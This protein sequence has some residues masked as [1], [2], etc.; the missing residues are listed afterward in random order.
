MALRAKERRR[1]NR[2]KIIIFLLAISSA[3]VNISLVMDGKRK[4]IHLYNQ[5]RKT[6]KEGTVNYYSLATC[7]KKDGK[8]MKEVIQY[9]GRLSDTEATNYRVLLKSLNGDLATS[10]LIDIR[11]ILFKEEK[12]YFDSLVIN[13]LW[14]QLDINE[15]FN[16]GIKGNQALST[17]QVARILTIN[18]LLDPTSKIGTI[19]WL[20][21]TL[22]PSIL[23]FDKK[24]YTKNKI[25]N[26]L[27]KIH[28]SKAYLEKLFWNFSKSNSSSEFEV[29]Y[30]DG[31][32]SWFEGTKC[33]LAQNALEKTRSFYSHVVGMML[34]T[35]RKGYPVAWE[36]VEGKKK[37]TTEL[38][39]LIKRVREQYNIK[40]ITYCF[41]RGVASA[42]NFDD[43]ERHDSKFI[44]GIKDNQ[45]AP[46]FDLNAFTS[47][48]EKILNYCDLPMEEQKGKIPINGFYTSNKKVFYRDL[49]VIKSKRH[50]VSFNVEIYNVEKSDRERRINQTAIAINELN[51]LF[52]CRK[53]DLGYDDAEKKLLEIFKKFR[54]GHFF[55][56]TLHPIVLN[57]QV[58][59]YSVTIAALNDKIS[60]SALTDGMMVY[61][62]DHVEKESDDIT[63]RLSAY[64]IIDHYRN[65]YII[66][67]AFREM[68]SFL[69]LRP[70]YVWT[71]DHV[72]AHYDIG[73]IGYFINNYIHEKLSC[74]TR[75][76]EP[77]LKLLSKQFKKDVDHL[78]SY[79]RAN[80]ISLKE[81]Y[82]LEEIAVFIQK[83]SKEKKFSDD[84]IKAME[85]Y[86]STTS[87]RGFY[88]ALKANANIIKLTSPEKTEI[89]KMKPL[90]AS[91]QSLLTLLNMASLAGPSIHTSIGI[92][93]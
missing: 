79:F 8:N 56:Y 4:R 93:Q 44:T 70:F 64:A 60:E 39:A 66:E 74:P 67:N 30:Y 19:G 57:K 61:I 16:S 77:F 7:Y 63:L 20:Q 1:Q 48:R 69:D 12:K 78:R 15:V 26:E 90:E 59:S 49:G 13:E 23:Q 54:T 47:T 42:E 17:E 2:I 73:I 86:S 88:K 55:S 27:S 36:V 29:Y 82:T 38:K 81:N 76:L 6:K 65:K 31:S 53:K 75:N 72:K 25:F 43:I 35:D 21:E 24:H 40:E 68:K 45:I 83:S 33:P 11:D 87:I 22:L 41:D 37:D 34:I 58:E 50:I 92:Y 18:R 5:P 28:K 10:Q 85:K 46:I 71:E 3:C 89:Y 51:K 80:K 84:F 52:S 14:L 32:T 9:L 62:T 91:F